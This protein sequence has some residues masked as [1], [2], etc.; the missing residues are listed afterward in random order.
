MKF[1]LSLLS[2]AAAAVAVATPQV[3]SAG[4]IFDSNIFVSGQGFGNVPRDL[5]LSSPNNDT[6]E[7]GAVG[8]SATGTITFGVPITNAQV[9]DSNGVQTVAGTTSMPSPLA[10]DQK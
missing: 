3:A 2:L 8:V 4:L 1:K 6:F 7:S 5:T 10:D 9:H